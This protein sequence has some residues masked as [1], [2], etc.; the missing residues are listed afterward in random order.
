MDPGHVGPGYNLAHPSPYSPLSQ[1]VVSV[2]SR[3][4]RVRK[5]ALNQPQNLSD[6]HCWIEALNFPGPVS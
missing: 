1:R 6:A 4:E 3:T 2:R 5:M